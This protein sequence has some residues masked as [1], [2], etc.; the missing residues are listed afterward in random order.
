M[1]KN[2]VMRRN[3]RREK[4]TK[5]IISLLTYIILFSIIG[6][7][8]IENKELKQEIAR[9]NIKHFKETV[10]MMH[11]Y[12]SVI[13]SKNIEIQ[14]KN[15]KIVSLGR[16]ID[17]MGEIINNVDEQLVVVSSMNK[18]YVDELNTLR[19]RSELYDKYEYAI[20]DNG[21]RTE[22]TYA[23]IEL[24]E[25]LMNEKGIDPNLMFGTIMVE[26]RANPDAVNRKSGATGYGQFLNST[27]KWV[28][29]DLMG[30]SNYYSDL[31]K[32]GTANI[33][34]MAEYYDYLYSVNNNT[35]KVVKCYSGNSTD[36]GTS[37]YLAKVNNF[38]K[39]VGVILN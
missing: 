22:L 7:L 30:N 26:S 34:M 1:N 38:T 31:R 28:W 32:D 10:Q 8:V 29:T 23:E 19:N 35:F 2:S 36:K 27:A 21:E 3:M 18:E 20:I 11:E 17:H 16:T 5:V 39:K 13:D 24:G 9:I 4:I 37:A 15:D 33:Q 6:L 12:E 25:Q 14:D